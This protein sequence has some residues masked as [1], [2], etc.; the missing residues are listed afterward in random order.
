MARRSDTGVIGGFLLLAG[1][2]AI[3]SEN[4]RINFF[5]AV[6][7]V[8]GGWFLLF[9]IGI[10]IGSIVTSVKQN[11]RCAHGVRRGKDGGC[12]DCVAEEE[13]RHAEWKASQEVS[14]RLKTIKK[15]AI[16]LRNA[17]LCSLT[18][19]WLS[20]SELYQQMTPQRFEASVAVLFRQLGYEVTQTPY[21]NDRGKDAIAWKDG[22]KYLIECKHYEAANV[23]GRRDLQIFVA[24]M[25]EENAE[26]GFYINTGRFAK[27]AICQ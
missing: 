5:I 4:F 15:D 27:T 17:E 22:K 24:A 19:K 1:I 3:I 9:L 26:A 20:K 8:F 6:A 21:S 12:H 7:S 13:R 23:I 2:A 18:T 16:A 11:K 14:Q 25:K 10:G